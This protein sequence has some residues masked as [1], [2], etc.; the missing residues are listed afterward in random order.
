MEHDDINAIYDQISKVLKNDQQYS[1]K[2]MGELIITCTSTRDNI[3]QYY[4]RYPPLLDI[5]ELGASLEHTGTAYSREVIEQIR[6][7]MQQLLSLLPDI[8]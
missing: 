1:Y 7:K 4:D 5:A 6:Y 2:K 3:E 8:K